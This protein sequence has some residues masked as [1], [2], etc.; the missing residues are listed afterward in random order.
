MSKQTL[1]LDESEIREAIVMWL[2]K[3]CPNFPGRL[4]K[5]DAVPRESRQTG[6]DWGPS[7][8]RIRAIVSEGG[9]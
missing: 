3:K 5:L 2:D 1:E 9:P 6:G 7:G 8:H 4:V